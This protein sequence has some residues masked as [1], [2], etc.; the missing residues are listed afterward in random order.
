MR[1]KYVF[2]Y[3]V[4]LVC[5]SVNLSWKIAFQNAACILAY[6]CG[7]HKNNLCLQYR[8]SFNIFSC[9]RFYNWPGSVGSG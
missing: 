9:M 8:G 3:L 7:G 6:F 4:S 2:L 5:Q 1:S